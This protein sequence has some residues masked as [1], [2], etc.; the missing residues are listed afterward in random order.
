L[1]FE[2]SAIARLRRYR[3]EADCSLEVR[4]GVEETTRRFTGR[5]FG[6]LEYMAALAR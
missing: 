2:E 1:G 6:G 5:L 3:E 4:R